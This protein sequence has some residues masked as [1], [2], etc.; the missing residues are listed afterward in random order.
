MRELGPGS[1]ACF[2][3]LHS[4][5]ITWPSAAPGRVPDG[6]AVPVPRLADVQGHA[7]VQALLPEAHPP[8][9]QVAGGVQRRGGTHGRALPVSTHIHQTDTSPNASAHCLVFI[10]NGEEVSRSGRQ[11]SLQKTS[12]CAFYLWRECRCYKLSP[13]LVTGSHCLPKKIPGWVQ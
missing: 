6:A 7:G 3:S 9:G 13:N 12:T 4:P 11:L 10:I 2:F 8:G 5:P 1:N